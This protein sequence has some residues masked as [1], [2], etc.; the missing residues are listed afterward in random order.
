MNLVE[1]LY[2]D[3]R[4]LDSYIEQIG[5]TRTYDK[6]PVW[7]IGLGLTGPTASGTQDRFARERSV[8]EKIELLRRHLRESEYFSDSRPVL[9]AETVGN[10]VTI[11]FY[12]EAIDACR[13]VIPARQ[14]VPGAR[15]LHIWIAEEQNGRPVK[16]TLLALLED[17]NQ[18][19]T[20]GAYGL[21]SYSAL[22][23][24]ASYAK[25]ELSKTIVLPDTL[26]TTGG[27]T[28]EG[29]SWVFGPDRR[30]FDLRTVLTSVGCHVFPF[31]RIRVLYRVRAIGYTY[32][33]IFGYPIFI[34]ALT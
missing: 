10:Q 27:A 12:E 13:I 7:S 24:L 26:L 34:S 23:Y 18:D 21:T 33:Q 2:V 16:H 31:R 14:G 9:I 19:D 5:S 8:H 25:E 4:R 28:R 3:Q 20:P 30:D 22:G 11:V 1:Y 32:S 6:I 17:F 15:D 29:Q